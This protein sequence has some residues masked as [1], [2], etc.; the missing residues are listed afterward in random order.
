[1]RC[2]ALLCWMVLRTPGE[3]ELHVLCNT[4]IFLHLDPFPPHAHL[5]PRHPAHPQVGA[6]PWEGCLA[7]IA[8]LGGGLSPHA[9]IQAAARACLDAAFTRAAALLAAEPW[10]LRGEGRLEA[11]LGTLGCW[12]GMLRE[13]A[14][15][16]LFC[17]LPAEAIQVGGLLE[18][19]DGGK[20]RDPGRKHMPQPI[21]LGLS[22][23]HLPFPRPTDT[24]PIGLATQDV[25]AHDALDLEIETTGASSA[26]WH[27]P[28]QMHPGLRGAPALVC[29]RH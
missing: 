25:F 18:L 14:L 7:L 21:F 2:Y 23:F 3:A 4:W 12:D 28:C 11:L 26:G 29:Q 13:P 16:R 20:G 1:M 17:S 9:A 10:L 15:R 6:L 22:K 8:A 27:S 24:P 5:A 19:R